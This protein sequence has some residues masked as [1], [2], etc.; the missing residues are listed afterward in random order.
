M[1]EKEFSTQSVVFDPETREQLAKMAKEDDRTNSALIRTLIRQE[2]ARRYSQ[3]NPCVTVEEAQ[4]F[5]ST[6]GD[7]PVDS[8]STETVARK[9]R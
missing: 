6:A 8:V 3:P 7:I 5:N 9:G 2:F 1:S 4:A